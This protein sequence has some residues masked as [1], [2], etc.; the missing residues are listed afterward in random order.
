MRSASSMPSRRRAAS[1]RSGRRSSAATGG[2]SPAGPGRMPALRRTTPVAAASRSP[3]AASSAS[4]TMPP[5]RRRSVP[6]KALPT[7][8]SHPPPIPTSPF[9]AHRRTHD[10]SP[11]CGTLSPFP[12]GGVPKV[13]ATCCGVAFFPPVRAG[14]AV[15][16]APQ[17]TLTLPPPDG[18]PLGRVLEVPPAPRRLARTLAALSESSG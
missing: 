15:P 16:R 6:S 1:G 18:T 13:I 4:P 12:G 2:R 5:G 8:S 10:P 7:R 11:S 9:P 17:K 3:A 14:R